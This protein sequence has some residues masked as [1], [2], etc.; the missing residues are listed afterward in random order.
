MRGEQRDEV[1]GE[2]AAI[3][4]FRSKE[5]ERVRCESRERYIVSFGRCRRPGSGNTRQSREA[6]FRAGQTWSNAPRRHSSAA[7]Q[8]G[9]NNSL[10]SV[11]SRSRWIGCRRTLC[12][13]RPARPSPRRCRP[14]G[15]SGRFPNRPDK[16]AQLARDNFRFARFGAK[17]EF[18]AERPASRWHRARPERVLRRHSRQRE[19]RAD[20]A[21][22]GA[23]PHSQ[24]RFHRWPDLT[25]EG[26]EVGPG[27]AG[28]GVGL[29]SARDRSCRTKRDRARQPR[30]RQ[31]SSNFKTIAQSL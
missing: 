13:R 21:R 27:G 19:H 28:L 24:L 7:V 23:L 18:G 25:K 8:H 12:R 20:A 26:G 9:P 5:Q 10:E 15:I 4:V 17:D 2:W 16:P 30:D 6:E 29:E 22:V 31:N 3:R 14:A 1:R 11:T